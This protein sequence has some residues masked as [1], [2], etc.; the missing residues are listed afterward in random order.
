MKIERGECVRVECEGQE[1]G[2]M[3]TSW[4]WALVAPTEDRDRNVA[5]LAV[6]EDAPETVFVTTRTVIEDAPTMF[7]NVAY[8]RINEKWDN[9]P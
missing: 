5:M 9:L 4:G 6:Y 8:V 2:L 3:W 1:I 7:R